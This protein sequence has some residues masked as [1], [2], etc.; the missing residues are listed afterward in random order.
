MYHNRR[1]QTMSIVVSIVCI[2]LITHDI[3]T[4]WRSTAKTASLDIVA[5]IQKGDIAA[6]K[7]E[8][9]MGADPNGVTGDTT[10]QLVCPG[11]SLTTLGVFEGRTQIVEA[12][13][14]AGASVNGVDPDGRTPASYGYSHWQRE[15]MCSDAH[16]VRGRSV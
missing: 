10:A 7:R 15:S 3:S 5:S 12:L 1:I 9:A 8:L 6:V 4:K 13:I 14:K 2:T 11:Q 16:T